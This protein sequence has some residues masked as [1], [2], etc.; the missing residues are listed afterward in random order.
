MRVWPAF[1]APMLALLDQS[2][3]YA[4]VDWACGTQ[5]VTAMNWVHFIFLATAITVTLPAW[6]DAMKYRTATEPN[7]AGEAGGR[8]RM[9]S[10]VAALSGALSSLVI[11][12]LWAPTWFLSPCLS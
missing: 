12:A 9:M 2:V 4:M 10:V 7:D 8:V 1:L 6:A 11:L 3:T 5:N